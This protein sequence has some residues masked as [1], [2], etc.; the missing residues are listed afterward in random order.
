MQIEELVRSTLKFEGRIIK[1]KV[2]EVRI[3]DGSIVT[4]EVVVHRGAVG[5]LPIMDN[6]V[7]LVR[8]YR[9]PAG[10]VLWEIP[11]GIFGEGETPEECA[12]R[13]LREETGLFPLNL[14]RLGEV[15]VSP[16]CSTEKI[17]LFYADKFKSDPLPKDE[18][19]NIEV[20]EF[21]IDTFR[22]MIE[23]GKIRDGKTLAS[24][25]LYLLKR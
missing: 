4:R 9:H 16:G 18:D 22:D 23:E 20:G 5:I 1:V 17:Y 7:F 15:F 25:C 6:K 14:V 12:I 10:E 11:A 19:E 2:D 21:D 3:P 24:F 13:E 8:Q